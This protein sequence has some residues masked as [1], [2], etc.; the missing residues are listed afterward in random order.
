MIKNRI[1][2]VQKILK[3]KKEPSAFI[4]N[5]QINRRYMTNIS[6]S[7]GYVIITPENQYF[8]TDSRYI[9][10]AKKILGDFYTVELYPKSH[11]S[12]KYY[13]ELLK[14]EKINNILYEENSIYLK[15]KKHFDDLFKGYKLC[16]SENI[17]ENMRKIKDSA[18]IENIKK[19]QDLTD[20]A[21]THILKIISENI[22]TITETDIAVELEYFMKKNGADG[23][24]F[25]FIIVSGKKSSYPHG[26]PE[27]I[28]LSKGFLTMDF[29]AMYNGYCTDMTRTVCI[30]KPNK[31]MLEVYNLVKSAQIAALDK[32]KVGIDG[33][34]VDKS[35][36]DIIRNAGYGKNFGHGLGH[37]L[38][39]EIHENPGFPASESLEEEKE[40][41]EREE[42]E[43]KENPNKYK[44]EQEKK[45]K[46]KFILAENIVITVEPGIYIENEFGL[47]IEDT[48]VIKKDGCLNLTKSNKELIII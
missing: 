35:A 23:N 34:E 1:N 28:K 5:S 46:N 40:R 33:M 36:R 32:I 44:E 9:E 14:K 10:F 30:G 20:L 27:N 21:F 38:G 24:A 17:L 4:I 31:K 47:R 6:T 41:L 7:S 37:S 22:K 43:K 19:A 45:E 26:E 15:T 29:G 42:K 12:E 18:E 2:E 11:E 48:V 13:D 16:E 3:Q 39:L 8:F 25:D